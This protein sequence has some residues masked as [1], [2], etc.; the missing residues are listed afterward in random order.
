MAIT[1]VLSVWL[2]AFV[3]YK[4]YQY[5]KRLKYTQD[6]S[7]LRQANYMEKT[8]TASGIVRYECNVKDGCHLL[9]SIGEYI[10]TECPAED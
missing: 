9:G 4:V 10:C 7:K 8:K 3:Y 5:N 6:I 1:M 2:L